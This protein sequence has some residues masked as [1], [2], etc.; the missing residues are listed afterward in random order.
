MKVISDLLSPKVFFKLIKFFSDKLIA[1]LFL[2]SV[3]TKQFSDVVLDLS[4]S[5]RLQELKDRWWP[6]APDR[7]P[8]SSGSISGS[9][10]NDDDFIP[11]T[12]ASLS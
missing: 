12:V 4:Q 3:D 11:L 5:G 8:A 7:C 2:G 10:S 9:G 1:D 6:E